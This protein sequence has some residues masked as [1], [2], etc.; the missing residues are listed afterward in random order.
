[1]VTGHGMFNYHVGRVW[2][3]IH[4]WVSIISE[5]LCTWPLHMFVCCD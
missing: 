2:S 4:E 1:M 3:L 5:N